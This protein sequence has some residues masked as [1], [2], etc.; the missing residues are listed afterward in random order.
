MPNDM[1]S[2]DGFI[3]TRGTVKDAFAELIVGGKGKA[4]DDLEA[5]LDS[6]SEEKEEPKKDTIAF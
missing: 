2:Y 6:S 1:D 5:F 4:K 3:P